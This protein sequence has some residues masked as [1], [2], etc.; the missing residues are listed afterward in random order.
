MAFFN[1]GN[2]ST[3]EVVGTVAGREHEDSSD[4]DDNGG[5]DGTNANAN[6]EEEEEDCTMANVLIWRIFKLE[7][8]LRS[9]KL[10]EIRLRD[11]MR[12][13]WHPFN[14]NQFVLLHD[15]KHKRRPGQNAGKDEGKATVTI[16]ADEANE[17]NDGT[18]SSSKDNKDETE[19]EAETNVSKKEYE[20]H[21]VATFVE[22]TRL[23][24][25][26]HETENHAL[27][28]CTKSDEIGIDNSENN[29]N[30]NANANANINANV[31][32]NTNVSGGSTKLVC[33]GS[34]S[35]VGIHDL[36]W[37]NQ[38]T[39]HVL[40]A[41][42]DGSVK[43]WDLRE[44][45]YLDVNTGKEVDQVLL[46]KLRQSQNQQQ[47][48]DG[49]SLSASTSTNTSSSGNSCSSLNLVESAKC[50]M[51]VNANITNE[52][53]GSKDSE[54]RQCMF[55]PSYGDAS[56]NLQPG[57]KTS[58]EHGV[59][60]TTSPFLTVSKRGSCVT[61]WSPFT[62]A[63]RKPTPVRTFQLDGNCD[64]VSEYN[65]SLCTV[66]NNTKIAMAAT[67]T[68]SSSS[69]SSPLPCSFVLFA[70][71]T[72]G[73]IYALHLNSFWCTAPPSANSCVDTTGT[74]TTT[75]QSSSSSPSSLVAAV[76]GFD[77]II[78]LHVTQPVYSWS[79][80][81]SSAMAISNNDDD[82]ENNSNEWSIDLFCVQSKAVQLLTL[83]KSML[84]K[85]SKSL[86]LLDKDLPNGLTVK[87]L[88]IPSPVQHLISDDD[89][90]DDDDFDDEDEDVDVSFEEE[91][92]DVEQD[93]EDDIE[94]DEYDGEDM[95]YNEDDEEDFDESE[96]QEENADGSKTA[97][98]GQDQKEIFQNVPPPPMPS[99]FGTGGNDSNPSSF[100]NWLGN[101]AGVSTSTPASAGD[102][103]KKTEK[104]AA[105]S[106]VP[107][108]PQ[109]TPATEPKVT[110]DLST[111]PL[112]TIPDV[113]MSEKSELKDKS[114]AIDDVV[115]V[116][117]ITLE[118]PKATQR[119]LSPIE[120]LASAAKKETKKVSTPPRNDIG[121]NGKGQQPKSDKKESKRKSSQKS[122]STQPVPIPSKDGKI[123]ILKREDVA[124]KKVTAEKPS[125][126][127]PSSVLDVASTSTVGVTKEE[128]EDIVRRAV[129]GH[130]QKQ[131]NIITAEIQ[132]AVRY[133]VQSGLV[134]TLNKTVAQT[135][136][137]TI[138]KTMK[139]TV[140][141]S[142]KE[143]TKINT[144]ELATELASKLKDPL[145]DSFYKS[146][147]ELMIPAYESG[148]RQMFDQISS[149]IER[150]LDLKQKDGDE[151][152]KNAKAMED[153]MNRLD[154]MSK[155][156][157]VLIQGVA[158][159]AVGGNKTSQTSLPSAP[160]VV[161]KIELIK[162]K[163]G[164]FLEAQEFEKAFTTALSAENP[165]IAVWTC[166][167]ADLSII[168][169]SETPKLSQPIMLCLMQQLGADFSPQKD[170]DLKVKLAWLQ[171]IALTLDPYNDSI[172]RHLVSV[173]QQLVANLQTKIAEPNVMLRREMQML[174]Q[175]IRGIGRS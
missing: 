75:I 99:F 58:L 80:L 155:T 94:Y 160:P 128:V 164:E 8:E 70:D 112:P 161:D 71:K 116:N 72:R 162:G 73:N 5:E 47:E 49:G 114:P 55:L 146:M 30:A 117:E 44:T 63:E 39:R 132:K 96:E 111:V 76:N 23:M 97:S 53:E 91:E 59:Y 142:V 133:E 33:F 38:D 21:T 88:V 65:V 98:Q 89:D 7:D 166:K 109:V 82:G 92:Y 158:K 11:A 175:V 79:T 43:L 28:N 14:A 124:P 174:V 153:M 40:T 108:T 4:G 10:L 3:N 35:K 81:I 51:T 136:E 131:E 129:S 159:V 32:V 69:S 154:A 100:T 149:S 57:G 54:I 93:D 163:I 167:S 172:K 45:V 84:L 64:P 145:V 25:T 15:N 74:N 60:N 156:M 36:S 122:K 24:T 86:S 101:L 104:E 52:P 126:I 68:A 16:A 168:L 173:C 150:G 107:P 120:I 2:N 141:K 46:N 1:K 135:L 27:C 125:V 137:Q 118:K 34:A 171:S 105:I 37:S 119:Y 17:A 110:V 77:Y 95:N 113:E 148:T 78:P 48:Q 121:I 9:E 169:E 170:T 127:V 18:D 6:G 67:N 138:S 20:Y 56:H 42:K 140:S 144:N 29:N 165:D 87:D 61:L 102:T 143:A 26:K 151:N 50:I 90:E 130:F 41:H 152:E 85:D 134:P 115:N 19:T 139:S 12:I 83:T 66:P 157:E 31:N 147:R 22:S 106:V 103:A 123:A 62:T 13:V